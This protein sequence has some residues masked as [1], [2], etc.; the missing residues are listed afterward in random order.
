VDQEEVDVVETEALERA[1]KGRFG[2]V[3]VDSLLAIGGSWRCAAPP[4]RRLEIGARSE[5]DRVARARSLLPVV[6]VGT[7]G[8]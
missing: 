8:R 2:A 7:V 6:P 5:R 1:L 3:C 4:A